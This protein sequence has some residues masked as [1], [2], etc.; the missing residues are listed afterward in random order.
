MSCSV[1]NSFVDERDGRRYKTLRVPILGVNGKDTILDMTWMASNLSFKMDSSFCYRYESTNCEDYGRYYYWNAAS[2]ACPKGWHIP[3]VREWYALF[4]KF[5][6]RD[7]AAIFLKSGGSSGFNAQ[8]NGFIMDGKFE[9]FH[10]VASFWHS[11]SGAVSFTYADNIY[12]S[13][14]DN[15]STLGQFAHCVRCLK[16]Y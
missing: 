16:D 1:D 6:R 12:V 10:D 4:N 14:T 5:G 8:K 11:D 2:V 13:S 7:S 3:S 15:V 9:S